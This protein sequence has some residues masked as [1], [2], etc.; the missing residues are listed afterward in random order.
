M[1]EPEF[2]QQRAR[3]VRNLAD[4][5]AD[6]FIKKRLQD[7]ASRYEDDRL[8]PPSPLTPNDLKFTSRSTGSER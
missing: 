8:K 3:T 6:P 2:R 5:A 1:L 4:Q 7:L